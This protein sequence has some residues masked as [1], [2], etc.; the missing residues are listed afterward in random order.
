MKKI[1]KMRMERKMKIKKNKYL[2]KTK[3]NR[4]KMKEERKHMKMKIYL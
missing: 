3:K 2:N 4:F 1:G